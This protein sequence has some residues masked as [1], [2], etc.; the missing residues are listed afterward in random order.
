MMMSS[1]L[2]MS[3][4]GFRPDSMRAFRCAQ[5]LLVLEINNDSSPALDLERLGAVEFLAANPFLVID[6]GSPDATRLILAGFSPKP[7]TYA[8]PGQRFATRRS[9]LLS[10]LASMVSMGLVAIEVGQAARRIRA[11]PFGLERA[12]HLTSTYA[13]AFRLSAEI[14]GRAVRKLSDAQLRKKLEAWLRA[15]PTMYDLIEYD[16]KTDS[17]NFDA[18]QLIG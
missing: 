5:L 3:S 11:T 17:A 8:A 10:D 9:R 16:P 1:S 13:D 6:D 7:L 12:T 4:N 14:A 2:A 18:F 15:D